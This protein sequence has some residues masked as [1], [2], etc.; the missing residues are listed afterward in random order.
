VGIFVE[1]VIT[2][3][4]RVGRFDGIAV[5]ALVVFIVGGRLGCKV[6]ERVGEGVG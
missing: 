5:G 6:G 2:T 3:G 4:G 1:P